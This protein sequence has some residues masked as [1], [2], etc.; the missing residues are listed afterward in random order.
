MGLG[1][2]ALLERI[3]L[4]LLL[5]HSVLLPLGKGLWRDRGQLGGQL[6]TLHFEEL[7]D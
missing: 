6:V 5:V 7:L 4:S 2:F 1:L 3:S